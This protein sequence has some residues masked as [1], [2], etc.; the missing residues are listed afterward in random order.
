[1]DWMPASAILQQAALAMPQPRNAR[2]MLEAFEKA[3]AGD[4]GGT[5]APTA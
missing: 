4:E 3:Q 2:R 5:R 1:M